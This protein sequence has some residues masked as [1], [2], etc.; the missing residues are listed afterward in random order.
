MDADHSI[1]PVPLE[2]IAEI[3][4]GLRL[5][6]SIAEDPEYIRSL[7]G[8]CMMARQSLQDREDAAR[9]AEGAAKSFAYQVV[10][11]PAD[12]YYWSNG[13]IQAMAEEAARGMA[14]HVA[15]GIRTMQPR[16][17]PRFADLSTPTQ[18]S[19]TA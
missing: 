11:A 8:V 6:S 15:Q 12:G 18:N 3:E 7:L 19:E 17:V 5:I 9:L 1:K 4:A 13:E 16:P 14:N 2:K 10:G